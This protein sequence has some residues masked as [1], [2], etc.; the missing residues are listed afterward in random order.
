MLTLYMVKA[1]GSSEP[2]STSVSNKELMETSQYH[3]MTCIIVKF[4]FWQKDLGQFLSIIDLG[5]IQK[6]DHF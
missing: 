1:H 4:Y 2:H 6:S 5:E 3:S